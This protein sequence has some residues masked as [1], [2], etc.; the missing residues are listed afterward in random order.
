[1][2]AAGRESRGRFG[3]FGSP[4]AGAAI[5]ARLVVAALPARVA[6]ERVVMA[7]PAGIP[8]KRAVA[9]A[10]YRAGTSDAPPTSPGANHYRRNRASRERTARAR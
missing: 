7:S 5:A 4:T 1:M 6:L 2:I 10:R 8:L 3:Y 9:G